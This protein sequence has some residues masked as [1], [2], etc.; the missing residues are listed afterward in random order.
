[1]FEKLLS[2]IGIGL[3]KVN[4][5]L[6]NES[7]ERGMDVNGEVRIFGGKA[8]HKISEIYIHID[9]DF[10]K[11]EDYTDPRNIIEPIL[12]IRINKPIV[13]KPHEDTVIPFSFFMPY[14]MP[15]SFKNQQVTIKTEIDIDYAIYDLV[16]DRGVNVTDQMIEEILNYFTE[17]GFTHTF[18]SGQCRH[19]KFDDD[20][21]THF[22]QTF[23][24]TND[25]GVKVHFVG[26]SKDIHI[27]IIKG[28]EVEY[29]LI[30]RDKD[31]KTQLSQLD[32]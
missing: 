3:A 15:I 24:L 10:D 19:K 30:Y 7:I 25:D 5:V 28:E 17:K 27:Y 20:N 18:K 21:P 16:E 1:M 22:L 13:V 8:E 32:I 4:T 31:L 12:E 23:V 26:N 14:Y 9:S 2:S 6:L 11:D 29:Y